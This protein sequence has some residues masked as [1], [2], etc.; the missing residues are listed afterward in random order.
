MGPACMWQTNYYP[1]QSQLVRFISF[2]MCRILFYK[3]APTPLEVFELGPACGAFAILNTIILHTDNFILG[4][5]VRVE[6]S[7][8]TFVRNLKL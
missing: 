1:E 7:N 8:K 5:L 6:L 2:L 3:S 4:V